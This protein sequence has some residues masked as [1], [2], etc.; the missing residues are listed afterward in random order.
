MSIRLRSKLE[1][2]DFKFLKDMTN[3]IRIYQFIR[4]KKPWTDEKVNRFLNKCIDD[5]KLPKGKREE[6][7]YIIEYEE[8]EE[9]T[10]IGLIGASQK[11]K[12]LSMTIFI[13]P[14]FQGKGYFS[15]SLELFKQE[16]H[17]LKPRLKYFFVQ[18][19][20]TNAKMNSILMSKFEYSKRFNIGK[21]MVD[22]YIVYL[23]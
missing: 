13:D 1:P 8:G 7:N 16:I 11:G 21:I 19:H 20:V 23:G 2:D 10:K 22:E 15:K 4:N 9:V 17:K 12:K 18:T 14:S 6:Y 5:Q 3:D